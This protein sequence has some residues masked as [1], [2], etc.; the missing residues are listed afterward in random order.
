MITKEQA[1]KRAESGYYLGRGNANT[2]SFEK[3][4]EIEYSLLDMKTKRNTDM[5]EQYRKELDRLHD[6]IEEYAK[7]REVHP[8]FSAGVH[9]ALDRAREKFDMI[10]RGNKK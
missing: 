4:F 1:K 5:E 9:R 3:D 7:E 10:F 2:A 8:Q 6:D